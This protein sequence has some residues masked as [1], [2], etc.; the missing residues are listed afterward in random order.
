ME[1]VC[2]KISKYRAVLTSSRC[3]TY[4]TTCFKLDNGNIGCCQS[5]ASCPGSI[6]V[7]AAGTV[8]VTNY[9]TATVT[10]NGANTVVVAGGGI[11]TTTTT[12]GGVF[13]AGAT[14]TTTSSQS[15]TQEVIGGNYCSTLTAKGDNLPTTARGDCGTI[16]V[17][18]D[19]T[20]A[21]GGL[22]GSLFLWTLSW[23]LGWL[24]RFS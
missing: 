11:T 6:A 17:V 13:I 15:Q 22:L 9:Q 12:G 24:L 16:L 1:L 19:A 7:A 5:G 8:T 4:G 2:S 20:R 10:Q 3:C 21:A 23:A 18:N 14:T